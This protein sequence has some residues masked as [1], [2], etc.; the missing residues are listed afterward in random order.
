MLTERHLPIPQVYISRRRRIRRSAQRMELAGGRATLMA[1]QSE[2]PA[3]RDKD[4]RDSAAGIPKVAEG[5]IVRGTKREVPCW[6]ALFDVITMATIPLQL[7]ILQYL[8]GRTGSFTSTTS[9]KTLKHAKCAQLLHVHVHYNVSLFPVLDVCMYMQVLI[10]EQLQ[11]TDGMCEYAIYVLGESWVA[12]TQCVCV[13][14][15]SIS[16]CR[17]DQTSGGRR[18]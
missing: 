9:E 16:S 18:P 8:R 12:I 5:R 10:G 1:E 3:A 2:E 6:C 7:T 15:S 14:V 4:S 13:S 11:E 17:S